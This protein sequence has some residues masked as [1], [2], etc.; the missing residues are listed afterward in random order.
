MSLVNSARP[1]LSWRIRITSLFAGLLV[2]GLLVTARMLE[3]NAD[4]LGTHQQLGLPPCTSIVLFNSPCPACGMT[5]SW[6]WLTRGHFAAAAH[7][8][9]GGTMLAIIGLAYVPISCYFFAVGTGT[10]R[11]RFSL[12][13]ALALVASILVATFQWYLRL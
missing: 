4:G 1:S 8:N 9:L 7:A 13:L 10:R 3:P 5:T 2:L 6:A 12:V 11:E